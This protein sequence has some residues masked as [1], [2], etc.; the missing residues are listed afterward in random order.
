MR[1]RNVMLVGGVGVASAVLGALLVTAIAPR[2]SADVRACYD[3]ETGGLRIVAI[4]ADVVADDCAPD[5]V[6]VAWGSQAAAGSDGR[7]GVDGEPGRD[8]RDGVAGRDG[9]PGVDGKDGAPG[10]MGAAGPPGADGADGPQGPAGAP[11]ADGAQ[12]PAGAPGADGVP[13]PAGPAGPPGADGAQGPAGPAGADGVLGYTQEWTEFRI[14]ARTAEDD[15]AGVLPGADLPTA[16][17][18]DHR[19]L[20]GGY[21]V[22]FVDQSLRDEP[23][24]LVVRDVPAAFQSGWEV[25]ARNLEYEDVMLT[26]YALCAYAPE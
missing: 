2:A 11:G 18:R 4:G 8:G 10:P 24:V 1:I 12:G 7:D 23:S 17:P 3:E 16:C 22:R 9:A 5:E 15:L 26:V 14:P 21:S 25:E 6:A 13:G 19:V 20:G